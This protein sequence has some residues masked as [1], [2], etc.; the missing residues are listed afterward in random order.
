MKRELASSYQDGRAEAEAQF[1]AAMTAVAEKQDKAEMKEES[2]RLHAEHD[3]VC[4]HS[5]GVVWQTIL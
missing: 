1:A 4:V 3:K 2:D 5:Y